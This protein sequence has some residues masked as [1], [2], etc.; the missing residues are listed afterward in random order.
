MEEGNGEGCKTIAIWMHIIEGYMIYTY[1][2]LHCM[3]ERTREL[4]EGIEVAQVPDHGIDRC[5]IISY[6]RCGIIII[7]VV[8]FMVIVIASYM[9]IIIN[10]SIM[11]IARGRW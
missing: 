3:G 6:G 4:N 2:V 10:A 5:L 1:M 8:I 9:A 7:I 11:R